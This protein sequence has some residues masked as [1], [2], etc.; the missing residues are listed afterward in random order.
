MHCFFSCL[1]LVV[2][3]LNGLQASLF[4]CQSTA[5]CEELPK[6]L[7][8]KKEML[9]IGTFFSNPPFECTEN[10]KKIGFEIDLMNAV[11][12]RLR[13]QCR[14]VETT[15]KDMLSAL[16][17][18]A[19]DVIIG[20]IAVTAQRRELL[21]FSD[22]Y[23]TTTLSLVINPE[24]NHE[25]RSVDRLKERS[26]AWQ[27]NMSDN[28]LIEDKLR[29]K[30]IGTVIAYPSDQ[31]R[32]MALDV[33]KGKVDALI[34]FSVTAQY[35]VRKVKNLKVA[36]EISNAPQSLGIGVNKNNPPLLAAI[37]QVLRG[38]KQD[39]SFEIIYQKWFVKL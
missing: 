7:T 20:G 16:E 23:L 22:P 27:E 2:F 10:R 32:E 35:L 6:F 21:N 8:L 9:T 28:S 12:K 18:N 19:F 30:E 11:C 3:S 29:R 25:I 37:N 24:I 13:L 39:G 33:Q 4:N 31:L 5:T 17:N 1:L 34:T 26:L 36:E 38:M 15:P 14:F